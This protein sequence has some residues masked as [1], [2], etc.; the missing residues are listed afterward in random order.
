MDK[1]QRRGK[2][3]EEKEEE[4]MEEGKAKKLTC[5]FGSKRESDAQLY[6]CCLRRA[7]SSGLRRGSHLPYILEKE[8]LVLKN[9]VTA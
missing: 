7:R 1:G 3:L 4:L 9:S 5:N 2:G 8:V 6:L